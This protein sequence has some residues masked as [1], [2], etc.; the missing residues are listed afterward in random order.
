MGGLATRLRP[1]S[2]KVPKALTEVVGRPFLF[3]LFALLRDKGITHSVLCLGH[4]GQQI[5][6]IV[7]AEPELG[8]QV[9]Y[10]FDGPKLLGT[11]GALRK[12]GPLLGEVFFVL[13]GDTFLDCDYRG[14]Y[15]S[16]LTSGKAGLM[17]VYRN[18]GNGEPSNVSCSGG[19]ILAYDKVHRTAD[20]E[21][22]DCGLG[23]L[24]REALSRIPAEKAFDLAELYQALLR[25]D[26]LAS[27]EVSKPYHEI[28]SPQG[29]A[30]TE[31][32]F[33]RP[34][35]FRYKQGKVPDLSRNE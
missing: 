9:R 17:T 35:E 18:R 20:M 27:F 34:A 14:V 23:L 2:E 8:L 28:G 30:E 24:R 32:Y 25:A 7:A 5:V 19:Q 4:L 15:T 13:N 12:A 26:D 11:G 22:V 16:F 29:I 21:H 31:A 10:S 33:Q 1:F 6:E 3:H